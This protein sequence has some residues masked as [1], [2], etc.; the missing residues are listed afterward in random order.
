MRLYGGQSKPQ[1][2]S[3]SDTSDSSN[4]YS[5]AKTLQRQQKKEAVLAIYGEDDL[6]HEPLIQKRVRTK[7][8]IV[9]CFIRV[10]FT[11]EPRQ[12]KNDHIQSKIIPI[13]KLP[14]F[15]TIYTVRRKARQFQN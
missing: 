2:Q 13:L 6:N 5:T 1:P 7:I 14:Q 8:S 12:Y 3:T 4:N 11:L 9:I 15:F 10:I